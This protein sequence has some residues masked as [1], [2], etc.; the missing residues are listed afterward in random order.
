MNRKKLVAICVIICLCFL[1]GMRD[2][3]LDADWWTRHIWKWAA[4]Y[5]AMIYILIFNFG[6]KFWKWLWVGVLGWLIWWFA[7]RVICGKEWE[8]MWIRWIRE[9]FK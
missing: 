2:G 3:T 1:D 7:V 6:K 8:S 9:L 5:G 4:F